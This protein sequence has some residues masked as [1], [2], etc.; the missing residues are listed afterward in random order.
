MSHTHPRIAIALF[1]A[2]A[3]CHS[4]LAPDVSQDAIGAGSDDGGGGTSITD[5]AHD[6]GTLDQGCEDYATA[7][8]ARLKGCT[9]FE[10]AYTYG[11]LEKCSA[12]KKAAC[13]LEAAAP[14]N[15]LTPGDYTA[16]G[17][18][19]PTLSCADFLG[20]VTPACAKHGT[21]ASG[22][23]CRYDQQCTGGACQ[24]A[25]ACG[26]CADA[27]AAGASCATAAC[28]VGLTC[29]AQHI[30][31]ARSA[32]GQ[33]CNANQPCDLTSYCTGGKCAAFRPLNSACDQFSSNNGC[34]FVLGHYCYAP[35][36]AASGTCQYLTSATAGQSCGLGNVSNNLIVTLCIDNGVCSANNNGTCNAPAPV[37]GNCSPTN[38]FTGGPRCT[39]PAECIGGKCTVVDPATCQ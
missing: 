36:Q 5:A 23:A 22:M 19:F 4:A 9:P 10:L 21:L 12:Q 6:G 11:T 31:V 39:T 24:R 34:N 3:G 32:I 14:G 35:P 20:G 25:G 26:T 29:N 16:C 8:C 2:A 28:D 30:C 18:S 33:A 37:G 7:Y 1:V 15:G 17:A 27:A 38:G 13:V